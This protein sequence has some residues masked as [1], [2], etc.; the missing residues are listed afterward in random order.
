MDKVSNAARL[1]GKLSS[2]K[3]AKASR[4]NGLKGGR[5]HLKK[6]KHFEKNFPYPLVNNEWKFKFPIII[7]GK[8]NTYNPDFNCLKLGC[9]IE[10][11]TSK[12]NISEQ[13]PKWRAAMEQGLK[14]RVY[15]WEGQEITASIIEMLNHE[16]HAI[17]TKKA[18]GVRPKKKTG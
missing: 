17:D 13:G 15:W 3:K 8:S 18:K 7:N 12:P 4:L 16:Q 11:A 10:V 9:Y 6:L 14:L 5:P 1:L 2:E